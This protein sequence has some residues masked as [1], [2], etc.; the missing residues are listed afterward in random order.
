MNEEYL[1]DGV[2]ASYDGYQIKLMANDHKIPTDI[3]F[4][5]SHVVKAL[6]D[7]AQRMEGEA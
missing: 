3:I 6:V 7:F 4:L 1:G 2:Y 5:D